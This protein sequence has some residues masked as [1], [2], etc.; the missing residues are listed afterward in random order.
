MSGKRIRSSHQRRVLNWLLDGSGTVSEIAEA[1]NLRMPHASLALRQLRERN[2]VSRDEQGSIRGAKHRLNEVGR[3]RLNEDLLSR[4]RQLA[5]QRPEKAEGIVLAQDGAHVMLGYVKPPSSKLLLLPNQGIGAGDAL[6]L[7]SNGR[8]GGRWA[9]QRTK[10]ILWYTLDDFEPTE[11]SQ[12]L[13]ARG[14]LTEWTEEVDRIGILRATFLDSSTEWPLSPGTWFTE[15]A[16]QTALP[17][18]LTQGKYA[19]GHATGTDIL[20]SPQSGVHGHLPV[21]VNRTIALNAMSKAA[22]VFEDQSAKNPSRTLPVNALR[23]WLRILHPRLSAEKLAAKFEELRAH[24]MHSSK[25]SLPVAVQ[26]RIVS[27]FGKA[28]WRDDEISRINFSGVSQDGG[29]VL[30][31]WY[32]QE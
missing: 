15:P 13:P 26:R 1:L 18:T 32:L 5:T 30:L 29:R 16:N 12:S 9:V 6:P 24:L 2:E 8:R 31:E 7:S 4:A 27:D 28:D 21:S 3:A 20:I 25:Q 17:Q 14:T 10:E 23:Y 19:L 11:F 22:L